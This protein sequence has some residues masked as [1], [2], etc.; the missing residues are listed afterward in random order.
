MTILPKNNLGKW[1]IRLTIAFVAL[2]LLSLV[3]FIIDAS[4]PREPSRI[5]L[6]ALTTDLTAIVITG[7]SALI[8]GS[9]SVKNYQEKSVLIYSSLTL[10]V[11]GLVVLAVFAFGSPKSASDED[12]IKLILD[13]GPSQSR[14]DVI[15]P[16][17]SL[18]YISDSESYI[19]SRFQEEGL[20][21]LVNNFF[22]KNAEPKLMDIPSSPER[23]YVIDYDG[24]YRSYFENDAG[25]W[26]KFR[27][28]N[29]K[30]AAMVDISAPS[31]DP[32]TGLVM[33]YIGW[34][35]DG[36]LGGEEILVYKYIFGRLIP[37]N[38]LLL[39]MS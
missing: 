13:S 12:I 34:A 6:I 27:Q 11:L 28:E 31:Y 20:G 35:G 37:I 15:D 24:K 36:F 17:M 39:S 10:T 26:V 30:V 1:S 16:Q 38:Y 22:V 18:K 9:L 8:T 21:S 2:F 4:T 32:R 5:W 3:A 7:L 29:P 14:Y 19:R 23:G 33:I 25:G